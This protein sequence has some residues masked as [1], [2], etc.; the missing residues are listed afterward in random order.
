M[1][2]E[3]RPQWLMTLE[4][5]EAIERAA[6]RSGRSVDEFVREALTRHGTPKQTWGF[7]NMLLPQLDWLLAGKPVE[8][9]PYYA[10]FH[11][12]GEY[13]FPTTP[14][15]FGPQIDLNIDE[16]VTLLDAGFEAAL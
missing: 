9:A 16:F 14:P 3:R 1:T 8:T 5:A 7:S 6:V 15:A 10:A 11:D 13:P 2:T 12:C 4:H